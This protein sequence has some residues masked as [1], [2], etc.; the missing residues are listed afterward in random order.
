MNIL[1]KSKVH[2]SFPAFI[3]KRVI[4]KLPI[5]ATDTSIKP[6]YEQLISSYG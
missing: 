2:F 4:H 1:V 3:W 5:F 6:S